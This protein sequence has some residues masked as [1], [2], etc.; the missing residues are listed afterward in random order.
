MPRAAAATTVA[1]ASLGIYLT[2][3]GMLPLSWLG[4]P[5]DR[6]VRPSDRFA[7]YAAAAER[8]KALGRLYAAYETPEELEF[9]KTPGS[10]F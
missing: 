3:F 8:L 1:S 4:V 2:H 7:L 5:P 6:V 10:A 9:L